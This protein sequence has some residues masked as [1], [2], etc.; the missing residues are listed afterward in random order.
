MTT[1]KEADL[2]L[3]VGKC[4]FHQQEVK[5]LG[6]IVGINGIRMDPEQETVVKELEAPGKLKEVQVFLGF[7]NFY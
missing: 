6:L 7:A 4:K 2:Y 1:L 3:K 5:Y